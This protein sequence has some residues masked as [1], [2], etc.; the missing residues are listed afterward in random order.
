MKIALI[1]CPGWG[2][3]CP[4]YTM[5][6]FSAILRQQGHQVFNFDLNNTLYHSSRA[7]YKKMWDDKDLYTFWSD[8]NMI[9]KF[10]ND[11]KRMIEFQV[12]KILSADSKLIGFTVHFTS[13]LVS[14]SIA[15][16]IKE[17]DSSR[18]IVFGGPECSMQQKG[19]LI[20]K[21]K[22]IDAVSIG[23]GDLLIQDLAKK[24]ENNNCLDFCKG[25]ILKQ[26][27]SVVNC[28]KPD[29]V[30]SIDSLPFPDYSY[31]KEDIS[32][33][34]YREP[35]RLEIFDSRGCFAKCHFCSEWQFWQTF[36][37]MSGER[38]YEEIV[39]QIKQFPRVD[40]FYFIG[41]LLNGNIKALDKLCDLIIDSKLNISWAGQAIVRPE[42][43][44]ELLGKM[45]RAGCVWLGYGIESGSQRVVNM[46]NKH[47]S[48]KDAER[49]LRD[50]HH[51]GIEVQANFMFGMPS[52]T[53]EDYKKTVN[54]LKRNRDNIDSVLASQ[55][56]CVIDKGTYLYE[57]AKEFGIDDRDHHLFWEVDNGE[58]IY[59]ERFRRYEEFCKIG[60]SL[61]LPET[62]GLLRKKPDKYVLLGDYYFYKRNYLKA[63]KY[64]EKSKKEEFINNGLLTKLT[65]CYKKLEILGEKKEY[66]NLSDKINVFEDRENLQ[67]I[68]YREKKNVKQNACID[69][70]GLNNIESL[71]LL[72]R[73]NYLKAGNFER[74]N[75]TRLCF[76]LNFNSK[77]IQ[78]VKRLYEYKF[79][80]KLV[81]FI[82]VEFQ[83]LRRET[84]L[85]GYPYWLVIDST[86]FCNLN[87]PF[88]PTGQGRNVRPK[89][90]FP[91]DNFKKLI[92]ELG[93]YLI[94]V[95]FCNWGEPLLN[96][97]IFK[98]V[99]CAKQ[100][101][102]DTKIDS[103]FNN[104]D[105]ES[106][107]KM[108]FSGLDKIIASVDG[109]TPETYSKYR[110]GGDF[111]KVINNLK[112]L[113]KK[114]RE[115]KKDNPYISWQF[116]VFRH[117]EHEID[118][119]KRIGKSL[120]VDE[121]GITKAFIGDKNWIPLNDKFSQYR[122][123]E[124][125]DK[126]EYTSQFFKP[127]KTS[128]CNWPWEA[129]VINSRGSISPCCSVE[130]EKDD[131]GNIFKNSFKE[132]WNNEKYK[133]ARK[134][135][136]SKEIWSRDSNNI[137]I[138]CKHLGMINLDILSCHSF[139]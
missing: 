68:P 46:M 100:Y 20:I 108:I 78:I 96:K 127:A 6:L 130:E 21:D 121:V 110:V 77:Q 59:P 69:Y 34:L 2:R 13:L 126:S 82:L 95:D 64:Y 14:L 7:E 44:S 92:E 52:E 83:K 80:D 137:C 128:I 89:S 97:N 135:I 85:L 47:F 125:Q 49:V 35:E 10:L 139:F 50:T 5:V 66:L 23:E 132:I 104:L 99:K 48:I 72:E 118:E 136:G 122:S 93:S 106:I 19:N 9:N 30:N 22:A 115:F 57:H 103:N 74:V 29:V 38:M 26:N 113:V 91:F 129:M 102:I 41:S 62:S 61:G 36:R 40:Y 75:L 73:L 4:P 114:K 117:N 55:S 87:C 81:N 67:E 63:I 43:T 94:H 119:V 98:M 16:M 18:F 90:I 51:V 33:S 71:R 138:N 134:Y 76:Y 28:G 25:L 84:R 111:D 65:E 120:G 112:L 107:E 27:G 15:R 24:L 105:G 53:E 101:G 17:E 8:K 88:C 31:F 116:L 86:N 123:N 37:S 54:F 60:L 109:I 45:R 1:Q 58:N 133:E 131:F 11:N 39:Y 3:D 70:D 79:W 42:M 12:E 56:F 32:A 124:I